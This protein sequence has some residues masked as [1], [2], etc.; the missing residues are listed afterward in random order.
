MKITLTDNSSFRWFSRD[1]VTVKGYLFDSENRYYQGDALVKY[2]SGI[3]ASEKFKKRL[4]QSN[5]IFSVIIKNKDCLLAA[6]DIIRSFPL[7][8]WCTGDKIALTDTPQILDTKQI[9][10]K[11]IQEFLACGYVPRD[12]TLLKGVYQIQAG[13]YIS[14]QDGKQINQDYYYRHLVTSLESITYDQAETVLHGLLSDVGD[15]L[16]VSLQGRQAVIPLSGGYDSRLLA[17]LLKERGYTKVICYTFGRE[18]NREAGRAQHVA[19]RLNYPWYFIENDHPLIDDYF[20]GERFKAYYQYA[21]CYNALFFMEQY[22]ALQYLEDKKLIAEDAVFVPGFSGDFIA[23]SHLKGRF[24]ER[25]SRQQSNRE[26]YRNNFYLHPISAKDRR[27]IRSGIS[28]FVEN[29]EGLAHSIYEDWDFKER[30]AKFIVN[31]ARIYTFY[32]YAFRLPFWDQPLVKFFRGL[33]LKLKNNKLLYDTT[34]QKCFFGK[35]DLNWE[36]EAPLKKWNFYIQKL[37]EKLRKTLPARIQQ[38]YVNKNDVSGYRQITREMVA[39]LQ[40]AGFNYRPPDRS[41]NSVL[42]Q[43]YVFK[44]QQE[45]KS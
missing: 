44:L 23:G 9:N 12:Q 24:T 30:Q 3:T 31:S 4:Q 39:E 8:Y 19:E 6:V 26:I 18:M 25:S 16:I 10:Y 35:Y 37:K 2:F 42:T 14:G 27:K 41:Y 15:R 21:S 40:K 29:A 11:R 1:G 22:F 32:N 17:V 20:N 43:W 33:P 7:F 38:Y 28:D 36:D 13:A 45:V 5:G 34:V